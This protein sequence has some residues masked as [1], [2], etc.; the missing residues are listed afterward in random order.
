MP[1]STYIH[2]DF[3]ADPVHGVATSH[4]R[5]AENKLA[6]EP[7][8]FTTGVGGARLNPEDNTEFNEE[9]ARNL[10]TARA[11]R[12]LARQL[13]ADARYHINRDEAARRTQREA[14]ERRKARSIAKQGFTPK[15]PVGTVIASLTTWNNDITEVIFHD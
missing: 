10:S 14:N 1:E 4:V 9:I 7:D 5:V 8:R 3:T 6:K 12:D 13:E 15:L 11:L 2:I